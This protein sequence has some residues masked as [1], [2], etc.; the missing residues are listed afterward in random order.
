MDRGHIGFTTAPSEALIDAWRVKLFCQSIGED[1]P[2]HW[3]PQAAR[4]AGLPGCAVP[5][6]FLKALE[7]E[8]FSSVALLKLLKVPM[9]RVLH[10]EQ[11]FDYL[12]PVSVGDRVSIR[13][14]I[15]DIQD[16]KE[17][18]ITFV[19]VDTDYRVGDRAVASSR[20]S[21]LVRNPNKAA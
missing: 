7:G 10:A 21:I 14:R 4:E 18:A 6:T 3:D 19:I 20:Q 1:N 8:H 15:S 11:T 2:V 16:K 9:N 13:R 17:G 12:A 5:P